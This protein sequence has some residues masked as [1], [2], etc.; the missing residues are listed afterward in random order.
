LDKK[1]FSE[2]IKAAFPE[3]ESLTIKYSTPLINLIYDILEL[4]E[5]KRIS[6]Q[7]VLKRCQ[8]QK[9]INFNN[10]FNNIEN[11]D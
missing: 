3:N 6:L 10:N 5:N 11:Q 7:E 4:D 1:K 8:A 9:K 2:K